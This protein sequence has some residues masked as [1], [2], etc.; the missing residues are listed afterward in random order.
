M[1]FSDLIFRPSKMIF[2][3]SGVPNLYSSVAKN[4]EV[5]NSSI[6]V[7]RILETLHR[8]TVDSSRVVDLNIAAK[9]IEVQNSSMAFISKL[10]VDKFLI[11]KDCYIG[12]IERRKMR[13]KK[14]YFQKSDSESVLIQINFNPL[15][16]FMCHVY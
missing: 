12:K 6:G 9:S 3:R 15:K 4:I 11:L 8:F 5:S 7:V 1:V 2:I 16:C 10:K 14:E 13:E